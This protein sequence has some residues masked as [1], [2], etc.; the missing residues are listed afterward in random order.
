MTRALPTR[1]DF[2]AGEQDQRGAGSGCDC[3]KFCWGKE[4]V[5]SR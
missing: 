2:L 1:C 4:V 3:E 5:V